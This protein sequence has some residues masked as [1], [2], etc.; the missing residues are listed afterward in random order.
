MQTPFIRRLIAPCLGLALSIAAASPAQA[1]GCPADAVSA[2]PTCVDKYEASLWTI[3]A[4]STR[5]INKVRQ[6]KAKLADLTEG[7]AT[8]LGAAPNCCQQVDPNYGN[9]LDNPYGAGFPFSGNW[10]SPVYAVSVAGTLPSGCVTYFQAEQACALSGKRLVTNNEWQRA[11]AGTPDPGTDDGTTDCNVL[12]PA[13]SLTGARSTCQSSWGAYDM[14]G[15]VDEMTA[16]WDELFNKVSA[17]YGPQ[18]GGDLSAIGGDG[19]AA[20]FPAPII[21]GG[22]AFSGAGAGVFAARTSF[23]AGAAIREVGLRCAR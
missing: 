5:L 13:F 4:K 22:A 17:N 2:G 20:V 21:R 16:D 10:T 3:P 14:V 15:N 9:C 1:V 8:Q 11:A 6:G 7:G 19:N 18:F 12:S 23:G